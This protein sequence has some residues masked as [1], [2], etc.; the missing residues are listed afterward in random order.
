MANNCALLGLGNPLLD[1]SATVAVEMLEKYA[2]KAN[3]AILYEK[4]D[5]YEE[6]LRDYSG[7]VDFIAG[8]ATQ[9]SVRV[10]QWIIG[11]PK[12]VAF[13]GC[14]G[15]DDAAKTLQA[16]ADREGLDARYQHKDYPTGRCAVLITD[17]GKNRSLV[18]K[19]D[20]AN[21]FTVDHLDL[22]EN[23]AV[24]ESAKAFYSA[25]FFLTV[26]PEAMLKVAKHA[27][28]TGKQYAV[29][30]SAPFLPQ[31]FSEPLMK[32][33]AL[34]TIVFG[35]ESEAEAFAEKQGYGTKDIPTI[36]RKMAEIPFEAGS[37]LEGKKRTVVI[38]QGHNPIIV[39]DEQG[40]L[41][42]I[43]VKLLPAEKIVDTN[44]AGDAFV[45]GFLAQLVQGKDLDT[46]IRCGMWAAEQIIQRS[47]C[48]FPDQMTFV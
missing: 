16:C 29:N 11:K 37:K 7:K 14:I 15:N 24:V 22:P 12:A 42:E 44:S 36:A 18:T 9:N 43:P 1:I 31:F 5:I 32:V 39:I 25:G 40:N 4:E 48:T 23:W 35:N 26:C 28:E 33:I 34:S 8:G 19:L 46:C 21:H 6:L 2:L 47:G 20:A 27:A 17:N 38:T 10:A 41:R 30:L 3:D 13:F 45:G